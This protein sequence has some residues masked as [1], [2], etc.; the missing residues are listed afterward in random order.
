MLITKNLQ[1]NLTES[2]K[3]IS[4]NRFLMQRKHLK[5]ERNYNDK[6]E[7]LKMTSFKLK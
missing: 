5:K 2:N 4:V 7:S 6:I 3:K 1:E